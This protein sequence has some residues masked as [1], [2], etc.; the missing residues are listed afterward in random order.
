MR[1]ISFQNWI[2]YAI[3]KE[4]LVTKEQIIASL[5]QTF[6]PKF[7]P[8]IYSE[9][10]SG[11]PPDFKDH[12]DELILPLIRDEFIKELNGTFSLTEKGKSVLKSVISE[13]RYRKSETNE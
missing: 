7:M 1:D 12:F 2:L 9:L 8:A 3:Q 10:I 11:S 4:K 5:E 13:A 6:R